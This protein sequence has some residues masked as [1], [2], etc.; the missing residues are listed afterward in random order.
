MEGHAQDVLHLLDEGWWVL[1]RQLA[2]W[3]RDWTQWAL[4][5]SV[6]RTVSLRRMPSRRG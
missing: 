6:A 5:A 2:C 3:M 4:N 1:P